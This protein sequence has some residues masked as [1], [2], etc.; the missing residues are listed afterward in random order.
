MVDLSRHDLIS[1]FRAFTKDPMISSKESRE[2]LVEA[3]RN[4]PLP[5]VETHFIDF[6]CNFDSILS[7][8]DRRHVQVSDMIKDRSFGSEFPVALFDGFLSPAYI[9]IANCWELDWDLYG[10]HLLRGVILTPDIP[11]LSYEVEGIIEEALSNSKCLGLE[12]VL[13]SGMLPEIKLMGDTFF[14]NL[15]NLLRSTVDKGKP[16]IL[17]FGKDLP[18][19]S[20][21][22]VETLSWAGIFDQW[23]QILSEA[24]ILNQVIIIRMQGGYHFGCE[25]VMNFSRSF[26]NCFFS[27][28]GRLTHT[29]QKSLQELAFDL[30]LRR[31]VVESNTPF[32]PPV[33]VADAG[34][35]DAA[36][37][38]G[39]YLIVA[40]KLSSIKNISIDEALDQLRKNMFDIF[41]I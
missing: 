25:A 24:G 21:S 34:G 16:I 14:P 10:D 28:D 8:S 20:I 1:V 40:H 6:Y 9:G 13:S 27:F 32:F 33:E 7:F 4:V 41:R 17:T 3:A 19:T 26:E 18:L 38:P 30:P 2:A 29:K 5:F 35:S 22:A 31:I 12:V 15:L 23:S 37:H 39:H 11:S 36:S